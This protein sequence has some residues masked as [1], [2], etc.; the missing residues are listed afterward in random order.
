MNKA[1][2][3]GHEK[4]TPLYVTAE[5]G[6][7]EVKGLTGTRPMTMARL[8]LFLFLSMAT[9]VFSSLDGKV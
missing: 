4:H 7:L 9:S 8:P 6:H 5:S 3:C 2:N 1:D